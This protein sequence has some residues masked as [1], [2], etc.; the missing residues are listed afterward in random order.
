[1]QTYAAPAGRNA[2]MASPAPRQEARPAQVPSL[3]K[4][5]AL[6]VA[7]APNGAAPQCDAGASCKPVQGFTSTQLMQAKV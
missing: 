6:A 2:A 7:S 1:M 3:L 5:P 4:A